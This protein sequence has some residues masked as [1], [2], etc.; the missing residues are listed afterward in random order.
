[1]YGS[2]KSQILVEDHF[3]NMHTISIDLFSNGQNLSQVIATEFGEEEEK[4]NITFGTKE[5]SEATS[6]E[7]S[8]IK[9]NIILKVKILF[10][11]FLLM[12]Y[13]YWLY[14]RI[15]GWLN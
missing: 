10:P 12:Q 13:S 8:V 15:I 14:D 5:V 6:V 4:Y 7:E 9:N 3:S 2:V 11:E 1:M